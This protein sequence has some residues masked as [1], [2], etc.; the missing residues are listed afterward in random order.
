M[1]INSQEAIRVLFGA[2]QVSLGLALEAFIQAE[3]SHR[4]TQTAQWYR[5]RLGRMVSDLGEYRPVADILEGDVLAYFS[6]LNG[7]LSAF[8]VHG[9]G[10]AIKRF[11]RWLY[12]RGVLAVDLSGM[13]RLPTLP[14]QGRKGISDAN[15]AAI[16]D[17]ARQNARDYA[18][19][20]FI[21]STACRRAGAA[22]LRL[23]DLNLL[24]GDER[25]QRRATVREKGM[26]SR[27]VAMDQRAVGAMREWLGVRPVC[28]DDHVFIGRK[29]GEDWR[30]LT[31]AGVSAV[32]ARYKRRLGLRGPC[33]PH[34]WRHRWA[35]DR[36]H[37]GMSLGE[38]SRLLGHENIKV[39]N[40]FYGQFDFDTL[41]EVADRYS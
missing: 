39:T 30:A 10:R 25:I 8:T 5:Q 29:P 22:D 33:S 35:R 18:L 24:N 21:E 41:Q 17:A 2:S 4:S 3:L 34:Q 14:R 9:H 32:I 7:G 23:D 13:V 6:G 37:R 40:D 27:T 31:P 38:A 11:W 28:E 36:I 26:K 15:L 19:L 12:R 16:L 1:Q 20:C